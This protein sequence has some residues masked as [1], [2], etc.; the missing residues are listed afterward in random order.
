MEI[1]DF[2]RALLNSTP[3]VVVNDII[4][5]PGAKHV[6]DA[7]IAD[8]TSKPRSIFQ[9]DTKYPLDVIVVGSAKLGFSI[10]EKQITG[11]NP[12]PRYREFD[13]RNSDI[14]LAIVSQ[15][16][17][18]DIWQALSFYSHQQ[19]VFPWDTKLASYLV[20]GWIRPDHFPQIDRPIPCKK[21]WELFNQF[22]SS[23]EFGRRKVRG[24][25]YFHKDFLNQYQQRS[26]VDARNA[27]INGGF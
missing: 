13:P 1:E 22:S 3:D 12:L 2:K 15:K 7:V 11:K 6:G 16:L 14:D 19:T 10:A 4:L 26:V 27:E 20:L 5:A 23:K 18:F 8:A 9:L 25:L 21:W 24:G 17:F